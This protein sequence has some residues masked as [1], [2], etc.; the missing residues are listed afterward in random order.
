MTS[1]GGSSTVE[2]SAARIWA[3]VVNWNGG[4]DDN[5]R[6]LR[7]LVEQGI[8]PARIVF[9]DNASEDGS[10]D[11]VHAA[12]PGLERVDNHANLGFGEAAN[13]GARRA[14]E[15]GA[16]GVLFV[17]NDLWFPDDEPSIERLARALAGDDRLGFVGPRVLFG[18]GTERVWCAGGRLDHRQNVS[19]LLG[20]GAPDAARWRTTF[21]VDYVA[22]CALLC[23]AE[24]LREVGL[25]EASYF[26][27]MEDV[28][29]GLRAR[30]AGWAVRTVGE[31]RAYHA[32]SSAT[33]G[34]Y[35]ARRKW[36]QGLN[37]VRFLRKH[38]GAREWARFALFDVAT[39]PAVAAVRALRG[40]GRAALAKGVG[41]WDGLRGR[42]V[43][44]ER[45]R[46]GGSWLWR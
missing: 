2:I 31:V 37:S 30:R 24:A 44:A 1:L 14:L 16:D 13:Q 15:R 21:D 33:G 34:G 9:V 10:R 26:A 19:T 18:D 36:M 39:L 7:S 32:P 43:T 17:N 45:L 4:A 28:E 25:F 6:C 11:A 22:G 27:Y 40:E 8:E 5:L 41:I 3:V 23:R 35:G 42:R 29:L 20:N 12:V 46:P 38:G